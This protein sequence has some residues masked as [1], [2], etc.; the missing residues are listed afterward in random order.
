LIT[1]TVA[2]ADRDR[3][4]AERVTITFTLARRQGPSRDVRGPFEQGGDGRVQYAHVVRSIA[5]GSPLAASTGGRA[6][7]GLRTHS[8][9]TP[10]VADGLSR[11]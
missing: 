2:T 6:A 7:G 5:N 8:R 3:S 1:N 9:I 10:L 4:N 11:Q